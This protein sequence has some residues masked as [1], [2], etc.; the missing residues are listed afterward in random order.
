MFLT[1]RAVTTKL[2]STR[3]FYHASRRASHLGWLCPRLSSTPK[4]SSM[5]RQLSERR[6]NVK[7]TGS[8]LTDFQGRG[9][10]GKVLAEIVPWQHSRIRMAG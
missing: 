5:P 7:V 1:S 2:I 8:L 3:T 10:R 9:I 6:P 4:S